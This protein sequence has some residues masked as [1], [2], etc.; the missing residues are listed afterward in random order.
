MLR[1]LSVLGITLIFYGC[2]ANFTSIYRTYTPDPKTGINTAIIDA[3]Q[4]AIISTPAKTDDRSVYLCAEPSP[5]AL[6][7][8]SSTFSSSFG[9]GQPN[10]QAQAALAAAVQ[11]AAAQLGIRNATIQ[12]LRD[13]LYR[14][15][16]AYMNGLI[17]QGDYHQIA[18]KYINAMVTLLAIEQI[19]PSKTT[20]TRIS[21]T[22]D[23]M[24]VKTSTNID[25]T[26]PSPDVGKKEET[27]AVKDQ[28]NKD[29][30]KGETNEGSNND[31][32]QN[33]NIKGSSNSDASA[34]PPAVSVN[35]A[36]NKTEA[37]EKVAL[38]A[39]QM[40]Q[41]FMRKDTVDYCLA[42]LSKLSADNKERTLTRSQSEIYESCTVIIK[43]EHEKS[44]KN[45][46]KIL[47]AISGIPDPG[48][49]NK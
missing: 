41:I 40:V 6:S 20:G 28:E 16:E 24:S 42:E 31:S 45:E 19:T 34:G 47:D 32:Q 27:K 17:K 11:E 4:R 37:S 14:Q 9:F 30:T 26:M 46:K 35:V 5:D 1:I 10:V 12:L 39:V 13:G 44:L 23:G 25:M 3:K 22:G 29:T 38:A 33:H 2:G 48:D 7:A 43:N 15:C 49:N 18:N 21:A 8:I 36:D